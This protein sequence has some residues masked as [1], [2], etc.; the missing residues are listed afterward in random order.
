MARS[1]THGDKLTLGAV[2]YI[3][4][5]ELTMVSIVVRDGWLLVAPINCIAGARFTLCHFAEGQVTYDFMLKRNQGYFQDTLT[6]EDETVN[7]SLNHELYLIKYHSSEMIKRKERKETGKERD[8]S[9]YYQRRWC[10][11]HQFFL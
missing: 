3:F 9:V 2:R 1:G 4:H 10:W 11:Y 7:N 6:D 5:V 8:T